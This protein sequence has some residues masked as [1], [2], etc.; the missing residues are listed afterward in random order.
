MSSQHDDGRL[1]R[2]AMWSRMA[3]L[4][5]P[6]KPHPLGCHRPRIPDRVAM[7]AILL[8]LRTGMQWGALD[9]TGLC[10]HSSA[11]RRFREWTDAGVLER[12]WHDGLL[13]CEVRRR[14]QRAANDEA[15]AA[16]LRRD[17]AGPQGADRRIMASA[18]T[19]RGRPVLKTEL[20]RT[21]CTNTVHIQNS[22]DRQ[23]GPSE[24]CES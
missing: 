12:F 18:R 9:A 19:S 7:D 15:A 20:F 8:L 1:L 4:I 22:A 10:S 11:H 24:V 17:R 14:S 16:F 21:D 3:P 2:D 23:D 5:P 13:A 6:P